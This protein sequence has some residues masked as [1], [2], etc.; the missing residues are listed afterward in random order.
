M[1]SKRRGGRASAKRQAS[2]RAA[3]K[4]ASGRRAE[5][6]IDRRGS[7]LASGGSRGDR[8]RSRT[9]TG[10]T[11]SGRERGIAAA[12]TYN[13]N[14]RERDLEQSVGSLDRR[15][16]KAL[17][18]G[19]T[20]LAKD[21]RSR[22]NK[23]V[24]RLGLERARKIGGGTIQGNVRTSDGNRPLTTRGFDIFQNTVDQDFK[25]PTRKLQNLYPDQFGTMYP[26][27]NVL[28]KGPLAFRGIQAALGDRKRKQIPYNLEDMPG[29]RYP[30][31]RTPVTTRS[32][33]QGAFD[34]P[35]MTLSDRQPQFGD[36]NLVPA[37]IIPVSEEDL[38]DQGIDPNFI[39]PVQDDP[40]TDIIEKDSNVGSALQQA[41]IQQ[42]KMKEKYMPD[43][44]TF[45]P[46]MLPEDA[47]E[48]LNEV[49]ANALA[50]GERQ[51]YGVQLTDADLA[52]IGINRAYYN[53]NFDTPIVQ[54]Q[55]T[56]YLEDQ[57]RRSIEEDTPAYGQGFELPFEVAS[58]KPIP[59]L[60]NLFGQNDVDGL[61]VAANASA[62]NTPAIVNEDIPTD[63]VYIPLSQRYA[64]Y[65]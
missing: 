24:K 26:I 41:Y 4:R 52:N 22:Q 2:A 33:R 53:M 43:R 6:K 55:V 19:N 7:Y 35:D 11:S 46:F 9:A 49:A 34:E 3:A 13:R 10:G 21:L 14:K 37:P 30:L 60:F 28:N 29:V 23:F 42:E 64:N 36:D 17:A 12:N 40:D 58:D 45:N 56:K 16:E 44:K 47:K 15:V 32:D 48:E 1:A 54:K 61:D 59:S 18:D 8:I 57:A 20:D 50:E 39:L 5:K 62:A 63:E 51:T 31:Q 25:D 38:I 65:E 27:T